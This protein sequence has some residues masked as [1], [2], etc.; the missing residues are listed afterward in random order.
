M[1]AELTEAQKGVVELAVDRSSTHSGR[2]GYNVQT[3]RAL[4]RKGLVKQGKVYTWETHWLFTPAGRVIGARLHRARLDKNIRE[5][6]SQDLQN[7]FPNSRG[8]QCSAIM[9]ELELRGWQ[10]QSTTADWMRIHTPDW[11][12]VEGI[13]GVYSYHLRD[14]SQR[15]AEALP[16]ACDAKVMATGFNLS[17]WGL[18]SHIPSRW[19]RTCAARAELNSRIKTQA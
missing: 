17:A 13:A 10:W 3:M 5:M 12:V 11:K 19:C 9:Q 4:E 15:G 6:S 8:Q 16:A 18:K 7:W 2:G 1:I 14:A